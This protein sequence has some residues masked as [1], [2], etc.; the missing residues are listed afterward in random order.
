MSDTTL[1][2]ETHA[3]RELFTDVL[4]AEMDAVAMPLLRLDEG[5]RA[6]I[7]ALVAAAQLVTAHERSVNG[8]TGRLGRH[9]DAL[10]DTLHP[11]A[12]HLIGGLRTSGAAESNSYTWMLALSAIDPCA[13][14]EAKATRAAA[15][16]M[17][18]ALSSLDTLMDALRRL[19]LPGT[20]SQVPS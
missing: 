19:N 7:V 6:A 8:P 11:E 16:E 15:A 2:Q 4:L 5:T 3:S 17:E 14:T 18:C 13:E 1:L 9:F 12:A 20:S 10:L